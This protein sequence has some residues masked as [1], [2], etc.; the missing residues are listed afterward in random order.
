MDQDVH[1]Y[2]EKLNMETTSTNYPSRS[3]S[4]RKS[5]P[6]LKL[7]SQGGF[8][9]V[10]LLASIALLG[11]VYKISNSNR[12]SASLEN[13]QSA[14]ISSSRDGVVAQL[15][16]AVS[17]P[18]VFRTSLDPALGEINSS[19][20]NCVLGKSACVADGITEYPVSLYLPT[21]EENLLQA[22]SGPG[23][24]ETS[25][26]PVRYAIDGSRCTNQKEASADCPFEAFTT[27]IAACAEGLASPCVPDRFRIRLQIQTSKSLSP[28][29]ATGIGQLAPTE[30]SGRTVNLAEIL[31]TPAG[32]EPTLIVT[33][34]LQQEPDQK[35][36]STHKSPLQGVL[37][38]QG[39]KNPEIAAAMEQAGLNDL[40]VAKDIA[41]V[42]DKNKTKTN[43]AAIEALTLVWIK[44]PKL[45]SAIGG[46][47]IISS[48]TRIVAVADAVKDIPNSTIA[49]AIAATGV[50]SPEMAGQ[51]ATAMDGITSPMALIAI[52]KAR[53]TDPLLANGVAKAISDGGVDSAKVADALAAAHITSATTAALMNKA[54]VTN[55][56]MI[57]TI[58]D[59]G[60]T[61]P[62]IATAIAIAKI[63]SVETAVEIS[64][65]IAGSKITDTSIIRSA[66]SQRLTTVSEV[67]DLAKAT[68]AARAEAKAAAAV[69]AAS[70][71]PK[72]NAPRNVAETAS[73]SNESESAPK[74]G[75]KSGQTETT[76]IT[77]TAGSPSKA[78]TVTAA[79][80]LSSC[81]ESSCSMISF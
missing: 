60:I 47:S 6:G 10:V 80:L 68:I 3:S 7:R 31:P 14:R 69:K 29:N 26:D 44:D 71:P 33:T 41:Q 21:G 17:L 73:G 37:E 72:V 50:Q 22:I 2:A 35:T 19:L 79:P 70:E 8:S 75:G 9:G 1:F 52:A 38:D 30:E 36:A 42:I 16:G 55:A 48:S 81:G 58:V 49:E 56:N 51:L 57:K 67:L 45:G 32:T 25:G 4:S 18:G 78:Q 76:T 66:A 43:P 77:R 34:L 64:T 20:Q 61:N 12:F 39:V 15:R 28:E 53:I 40:R 27:L 62:T 23:P 54:K 11:F 65:A 5:G 13:V 24:A 46:S 63:T 59:A 74:S